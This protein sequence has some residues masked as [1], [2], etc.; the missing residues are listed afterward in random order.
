MNENQELIAAIL[1]AGMLPPLPPPAVA[2]DG[3]IGENDQ[4]RLA[5][6]MLHAVGLYRGILEGLGSRDTPFGMATV[7]A[8]V[9]GHRR[10]HDAKQ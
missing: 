8:G 10:Q 9:N 2:P 7:Y 4:R 6:S 1:A 3:G 5:L